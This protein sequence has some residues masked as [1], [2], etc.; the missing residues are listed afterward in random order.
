MKEIIETKSKHIKKT[1]KNKWIFQTTNC[2]NPP[3]MSTEKT[4]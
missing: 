4:K 3:T 2:L 1:K